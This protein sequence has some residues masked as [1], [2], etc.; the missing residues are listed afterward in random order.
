MNTKWKK[1]E[2]QAAYFDGCSSRVARVLPFFTAFFNRNVDTLNPIVLGYTLTGRDN[3]NA[4]PQERLQLSKSLCVKEEFHKLATR[5]GMQLSKNTW[6]TRKEELL[7]AG[8]YTEFFVFLPRRHSAEVLHTEIKKVSKQQRY[9]LTQHKNQMKSQQEITRFFAKIVDKQDELTDTIQE[10][11]VQIEALVTMVQ[12]QDEIKDALEEQT[13]Q[14]ESIVTNQN[15]VQGAVEALASKQD[16]SLDCLHELKEFMHEQH[17]L[18]TRFNH[19]IEQ[20][21]H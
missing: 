12:N 6:Q 15:F 5:V 2:F 11:T 10:Q 21:L 8:V 7:D 1:V 4:S 16:R 19:N 18:Q 20:S 14:M 9:L 13:V 17:Q 3:S